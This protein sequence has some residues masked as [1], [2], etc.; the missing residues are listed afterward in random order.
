MVAWPRVT[1]RVGE[2]PMPFWS[3]TVRS[4]VVE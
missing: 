1:D 2:T 3:E 4:V